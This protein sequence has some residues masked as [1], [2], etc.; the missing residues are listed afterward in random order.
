M[1]VKIDGVEAK[2][3][4]F[5]IVGAAK[6]GT[7][8]LYAYLQQHPQIFM[9]ANKEPC[10][11]TFAG[12]NRDKVDM[13]N[14]LDIVSDFSIYT[15]LFSGAGG[16]QVAGEAS[17][18]Y[19]YSYEETI[20]NIKKYHPG[21]EK[22]KI[23][24]ILRDP[25]ERAFS[26]YLTDSARGL[27]MSFGEVIEKWKLRQLPEYY[28][29]IDYG[30]YYRQVKSY[31]DNFRHVCVYLFEDLEA[32]SRKFVQNVL[33]FLGVDTSFNIETGVKYNVSLNSENR[34]LSKLIYKPNLFKWIFKA[35]APKEVRQKIRNRIIDAFSRKP[36]LDSSHR[37]FLKEIYKEDILKLQD[38]IQRDL[39]SWIN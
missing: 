5:L 38:L 20:R 3:P 19:L 39:T 10:F 15:D 30:F 31:K 37:K 23:I 12:L 17:T 35:L 33:E 16:S 32:N 7:T 2:L 22:L 29:Y 8:S 21:W 6:S 9:S 26:H 1:Q 36:Q 28:N 4:D 24:I 25:A 18:T 34:L 13:Y 14:R 11:F 27:D